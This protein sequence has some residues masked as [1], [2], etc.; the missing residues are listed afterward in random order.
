MTT[1]LWEVSSGSPPSPP[2]YPNKG[3]RGNDG[4]DQGPGVLGS[5]NQT[6]QSRLRFGEAL[7]LT[8]ILEGSTLNLDETLSLADTRGTRQL[9]AAPPAAPFH[10]VIVRKS[11]A[12]IFET[13]LCD[14][15]NVFSAAFSS[16]SDSWVGGE[17]VNKL[18]C[19]R[20]SM[21]CGD[22]NIRIRRR[23]SFYFIY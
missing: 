9:L 18:D 7:P 22:R 21:I 4:T 8:D 1:Q 11:G 19:G 10:E 2:W 16:G 5:G 23:S 13:M 17:S 14:P 6:K 20:I 3:D 12:A 15:Q